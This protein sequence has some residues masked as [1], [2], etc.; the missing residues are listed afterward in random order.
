MKIAVLIPA[1]RPDPQLLALLRTLAEGEFSDIV[2]VNDGSGPEYAEI[3]SAASTIPKV[4][5]LTHP[6]NR[7]KRDALKTGLK[8]ALGALP[9]CD[10]VVTANAD[11]QHH[12]S[13]IAR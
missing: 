4:H 3:F 9:N 10:G 1:Y 11:G 6:E 8:F 2:L 5:L 7:G 13:D 12:P